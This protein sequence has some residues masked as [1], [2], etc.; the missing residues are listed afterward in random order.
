MEL[1][2]ADNPALPSSDPF[3]TPGQPLV[4]SRPDAGL[5]L[6][7]LEK[8]LSDIRFQPKWRDEASKAVDYYDGHQ[9]SVDRLARME[10]LGIP[11]LITNLIRP[12]ID[13]VLGLEAKTRT[14]WRVIQEDEASPV[15][16][17][18]IN[19]MNQKLT[20]AERET[21]A[22]RAIS[23]AFAS[24]IKSGIGWVEVSRNVDAMAYPYRVETVHRDEIWWDWRGKRPDLTDSRYL[25]RKR[26]FDVD[27]LTAMMP[28]HAQLIEKATTGGFRTWQWD[29]RDLYS[30]DLA[31]AAEIERIT[32]LD[33]NEWRDAERNRATLFEVWYR[34]WK[35]GHLLKL[36]NDR[37]VPFDEQDQRHAAAVM[38]GVIAPYEGIYSELR[39][40]FYL[41]PHK[42]YDFKSPYKH[43]YFPYVP[44][45]GFRE[46]KSQVPYGLVRGM[47]SPQ[48]VVNSADA[49]MHWML[50]ARRLIAH[51]NAIDGRANDWRHVQD[52][53]SRP[54]AVVLLDPNNPNAVFKVEQDFQLTNQQY[55]RRL[56]AANDIE[57][58]GGVYKSMLGKEGG[59]TSGIAINALVEQGS[60]TLAEINDNY[61][62]SR[63][64][65]GDMLFS[66]VREDMIG[67]PMAVNV[68][69]T[70]GGRKK[71]TVLLN[72]PRPDGG[73]DNNVALLNAK[74]VLADVPSTPA[75]RAQQLQVM[76]EV[77]KS[78][79]PEMQMAT[80]DV[81]IKLTDVP[82]REM[83]IE[84]LRRLA[85][86]QD[87]PPE[88]EEQ[89]M[90]Q[91]QAQQ[92]EAMALQKAQME[93]NIMESQAKAEKTKAEAHKLVQ[94]AELARIE[95]QHTLS[96]PQEAPEVQGLQQELQRIMQQAQ[97]SE[98]KM[99][100][101]LAAAK[102]DA[103]RQIGE[104][105]L[106]LTAAKGSQD[107][108]QY[109]IDQR[110][111]MEAL[112]IQKDHEARLAEIE[113]NKTAAETAARDANAANVEGL[114][115]QIETIRTEIANM[116]KEAAKPV[117]D[118]KPTEPPVINVTVPVTI[119]KGSG[120][121]TAQLTPK[122]G[123]GYTVD[124]VEKSK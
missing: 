54:D 91:Q 67:V 110:T 101:Q 64:Q 5:S 98:R 78:L 81:L 43:P 32:N 10:K 59:A 36:P 108:K 14:D 51:S 68:P 58:A 87:I 40:A 41:G 103:A 105:Q 104:M 112:R 42:L 76:S 4:T 24:Q 37:I 85:G 94:D 48:D 83:L 115:T 66:M 60:V 124:L 3:A 31:Y 93:A 79:P 27:E 16:E 107:M 74:V 63:R 116:A 62:F 50:N 18:L 75:F 19:A 30:P 33:E 25:I 120:S 82:D 47:I 2:P 57:N 49:R 121:K 113:A 97:E 95:L 89:V 35:R 77:V 99:Q 34:Q 1:T 20:E 23:D 90:Q 117:K 28:E 56:Q 44:F 45:W 111:A 70:F 8:L 21:R 46:D 100:E 11:P 80:V 9:I 13:A 69:T 17:T 86:I 6:E 26:R 52:E 84:R 71:E 29:T 15:P 22:D 114:M 122:A 7:Q 123:G 92:Q 72:Q 73:M 109:D 65:V 106:H 53:L 61:R 55:Q 118:E 39:V 12:T 96:T 38:A 88:M 102:M 119:E